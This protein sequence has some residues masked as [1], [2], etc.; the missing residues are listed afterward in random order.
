[1]YTIQPVKIQNVHNK[2]TYYLKIYDRG[3]LM[4]IIKS[5]K[6]NYDLFTTQNEKHEQNTAQGGAKTQ[7]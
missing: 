5:G 7:K 3:A 6:D 4:C 1:M 2:E